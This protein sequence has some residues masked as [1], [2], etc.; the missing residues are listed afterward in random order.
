LRDKLIIRIVIVQ[1]CDA[2][3]AQSRN[4]SWLHNIKQRTYQNRKE[5]TT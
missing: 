5:C 2:T 1:V 4:Q 3:A